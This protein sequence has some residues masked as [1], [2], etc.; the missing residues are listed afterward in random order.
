[1]SSYAARPTLPSLRALNLLPESHP[2]C[3][4]SYEH[5]TQRTWQSHR[6]VSMSSSTRTPSPSPSDASTQSSP[7]KLTLV[8]CAF[9]EA[10][11]VIVLPPTTK[12]GKGFLLTGQSLAQLRLPQRQLAKEVRDRMHPY[13]FSGPRRPSP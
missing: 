9:E 5:M 10:E 12:P 8:P 7:T 3:Y 11:A 2:T 13:R 6:R 4:D 1:M